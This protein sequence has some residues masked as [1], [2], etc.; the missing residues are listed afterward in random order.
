MIAKPA[1]HIMR[2][3]AV[4]FRFAVR[5]MAHAK[6][7]G[8]IDQHLAREFHPGI[9]GMQRNDR[10]EIAAS[11]VA[12]HRKAG[13]IDSDVAGMARDPFRSGDGI[14][15]RGREFMFRREAIV[16]RD[17]DHLTFVG[18]RAADHVVGFEIADHPSAAVKEHKARRCAAGLTK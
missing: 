3:Q 13:G 2:A 12:A 14:V 8:G 11:A 9:A 10:G 16:D 1:D 6:I 7:G 15:D 5:R 17:H 18:E 4:G